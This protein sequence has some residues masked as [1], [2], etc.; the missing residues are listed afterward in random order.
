MFKLIHH[1]ICRGI[2]RILLQTTYRD[3]ANTV[4]EVPNLDYNDDQSEPLCICLATND[5]V[6]FDRFIMIISNK[7]YNYIVNAL[8]ISRL[9][10]FIGLVN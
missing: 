1:F 7:M 6:L 9:F 2:F 3:V 10:S 5:L 8:L 4:F